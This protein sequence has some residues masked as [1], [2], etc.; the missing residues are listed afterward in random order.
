MEIKEIKDF[1]NKHWREKKRDKAFSLLGNECVHCGETDKVVLTID[2]IK[3]V[4]KKRL[5]T[6]QIYLRILKNP[7][8]AKQ[9]YQLLCRNDTVKSVD[10]TLRTGFFSI[11]SN[12]NGRKRK[13][14]IYQLE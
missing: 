10:L 11:S 12:E 7:N 6:Y 13:I 14:Y 4:G 9:K 5:N 2:H 8:E 3:A 1:S